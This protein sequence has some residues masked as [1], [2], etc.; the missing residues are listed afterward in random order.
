MTCVLVIDDSP[1]E[2]ELF[3]DQLI[4]SDPNVQVIACRG[5]DEAME[6]IARQDMD[7][8]L[9]DLRLDGE[10]GLDVLTRLHQA[11]PTLPVIVLTGQ[12]S[13]KA[14]VD[15]FVAGAAYYLPKRG[16]EADTLW[17][18]VQRVIHQAET[19]RELKDKRDALERSNRLDAVGQLAAGLAHDFNNQL[20]TLRMCIELLKDVAVTDRSRHHVTT[21]LKVIDQGAALAN[22]LVSFSKQGDLLAVDVPLNDT[23]EDIRA[24]GSAAIA[25]KVLLEV[26]APERPLVAHCDPGQLLNAILNLILNANDAIDTRDKIGRVSVSATEGPDGTNT[27]RISIKDNG[28][29]M[30]EDVLAKCI[31]PYFTTKGDRNGTGLGLAMVQSFVRDNGG[32]LILHSQQGSG[33]EAILV[34]PSG[35][36]TGTSPGKVN[37]VPACASENVRILVA[38]DQFFLAMMMREILEAHGFEVVTAS[39]AREAL[40]EFSNDEAVD[41][42]ITDIKM[43]GQTGV[44]LASEIHA[45]SPN[46]PVIYLTGY[47]D[48]PAH[49]NQKLFGPVMQKPVEP[50][51]LIA[52]IH[53]LIS[54]SS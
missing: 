44:E 30:S 12:G 10:D 22:R 47:A 13:E 15:A 25:D 39:S 45:R 48:S 51:H 26:I 5:G 34:L 52:T 3:E 11:R 19:E 28:M 8:V 4:S 23:L 14:A 37:P 38:E 17:I 50:D 53:G 46:L 35:E 24:L 43:P 18:A 27:V 36:V 42:L 21:A 7:C 32:D 1:E 49:M 29:G 33:T 20:G 6:Q 31:D 9:L 2:R 54:Q 16:L 40:E 41:I